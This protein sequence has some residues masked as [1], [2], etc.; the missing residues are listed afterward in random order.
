MAMPA[1]RPEIGIDVAKDNLVIHLQGLNQTLTIDNTPQAIRQWL[2]TLPKGCDIAIEA[3]S[4]YHMDVTERA[5]TKGH[6][7]YVVDGYRLSN[8]RKGVGGRAKTDLADAQLLARYLHNEK[9]ELR[10]WSPP[11]KA[12]RLLQ[13]LLRRR[14]AL[15][16]ARTALCQS[17][18]GEPALKA[19]L[20]ALITEMD[21]ID[22][23]I[24]KRL[25]NAVKEAGLQDQVQRCEAINGIGE[26]T[27]IALVMAFLRG[28][29]KNSDAFVAFLGLDVRVRDSGKLTGKRKLTKQGDTEVR[30]LLHCAAMS[31]SRHPV[32]RAFYQRYRDR[33]LKTTQALVILARKMARTAFALMKQQQ[34]YCPAK[35]F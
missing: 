13:S 3:T 10:Q 5:H 30:R 26:I 19:P 28:D 8:Y 33:G 20:H 22:S 11:P 29:F 32:W 25:K 4:T 35:L 2:A 23:L 14:A 6:R 16:K 31:A 27:A 21:R 15:V 18:S 34:A 7:V 24:Q 9:D 17:L 12:Y 1:S